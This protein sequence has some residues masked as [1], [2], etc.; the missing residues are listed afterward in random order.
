VRESNRTRP[1]QLNSDVLKRSCDKLF[2]TVCLVGSDH[3]I[4]GY[5]LLQHHP[6]H[7]NV[8][9]GV[10][11]IAFALQVA[12]LKGFLQTERDLSSGTCNFSRHKGFTTPWT[13]VVEKNPVAYLKAKASA[14]GEG[15]IQS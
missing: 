3:I 11:P 10:P 9:F 8:I 12:E 2:H 13:L 14:L 4:V 1:F 15:S 6:H 7:S 5:I